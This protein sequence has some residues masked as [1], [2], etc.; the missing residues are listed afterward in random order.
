MKPAPPVTA[1]SGP[2]GR[3]GEV[4][5][6]LSRAVRR[7]SMHVSGAVRPRAVARRPPL[8]YDSVRT[9]GTDPWGRA[10]R[11]GGARAGSGGPAVRRTS[12]PM[13][14]VHVVDDRPL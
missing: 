3:A 4:T 8:S 13:L 1:T 10:G 12:P 7:P 11:A 5:A 2:R 14:R 6:A 9:A